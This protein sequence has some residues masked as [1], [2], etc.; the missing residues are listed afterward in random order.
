MQQAPLPFEAEPPAKPLP[1]PRLILRPPVPRLLVRWTPFWPQFAAN[2]S[3]FLLGNEPDQNSSSSP[4]RFWPDVFVQRPMPW[5]ELGSS[6]VL[7]IFIA[8]FIALT[9]HLWLGRSHVALEDATRHTTLSTYKTEDFLPAFKT[10]EPKPSSRA[11]SKHD[12]VKSA[13]E[14]IS[15]PPEPDNSEQTI[16]NLEHPELLQNTEPLPNLVVMPAPRFAAEAPKLTLPA[17]KFAPV[18]PKIEGVQEA[19]AEA[20]SVE[21]APITIKQDSGTPVLNPILELPATAQKVEIPQPQAPVH[22]QDIANGSAEARAAAQVLVLNAR[23]AM[24]FKDIKLP[25]GSRSGVFATSPSARD[26]AA[27]TPGVANGEPVREIATGGH[28]PSLGGQTQSGTGVATLP[29]GI[30]IGAGN[31]T[32]LASAINPAGPVVRV[33]RPMR[34]LNLN[35]PSAL[36]AAIPSSSESADIPRN[37]SAIAPNK[38]TDEVFGTKR[39]YSLQID[40]PNL[41]SAGG[42]WVIRFAELKDSA[43]VGE[44]STPVPTIKVDP[45]Y[46]QSLQKEGVQ[47]MVVLFA[48]IHADGTVGEIRVLHGLHDRLDE[49]AMRAL[50]RWKFKPAT[51][52]GA[53]VDIEAVV[54]IP[55]RPGRIS[56]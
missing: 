2:L 49:S 14:V 19:R 7:H 41:T 9:G 43:L 53:P 40:L 56:F 47:G 51:K 21:R 18:M 39:V 8:I 45:A 54:Q 10:S 22:P 17:M 1:P 31:P 55:F 13:Q 4:G 24:D 16:V 15:V 42:S 20:V 37:A 29:P 35:A 52:S 27:G 32:E 34:K 44:L 36:R 25:D 6:G 30:S 23:P 5:K 38:P 12:P 26:G 46:P 28:M 3:D 11:R 50:S 48:V 33:Q